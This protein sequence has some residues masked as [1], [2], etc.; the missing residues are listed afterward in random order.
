MKR[1]THPVV[2]QYRRPESL[3]DGSIHYGG[4]IVPAQRLMASV[5]AR[6][7]RGRA[8][9]INTILEVMLP[10][11]YASYT[12]LQQHLLLSE[13]LESR[14]LRCKADI[15]T[16]ITEETLTAFRRNRGEI[17]QS[18]RT[19]VEIGI[20]PDI[21]PTDT[22]EKALF[23]ALYSDFLHDTRSSVPHLQAALDEWEDPELF[24]AR[25]ATVTPYARRGGVAERDSNRICDRPVPTPLGRPAAFYFQGFVYVRPMQS[26][27]MEAAE[28]TN[29][30]VYHLR[31]FDERAPE[32][33]DVW[34]LNPHFANLNEVRLVDDPTGAEDDIEPS[35][36]ASANSKKTRA[37][38]K[39]LSVVRFDDAF[40][41]ARHVQDTPDTALVAPMC[42]DVRELLETFVESEPEKTR[43]LAYPV[44]R[45]L[46]SL[47]GMWNE[48]ANTL[49][50]TP[51]T[52]RVCLAT[53][54]ADEVGTKLGATL[55]V[56]DRVAP[57]FQD[58]RRLSDWCGR[59][60]RLTEFSTFFDATFAPNQT[61][62]T[63]DEAR[64]RHLAASPLAS[65]AV[66]QT[67]SE[68]IT[69]L[70]KAIKR[71]VNDASL[72][73]GEEKPGEKARKADGSL[74]LR[75]HFARLKRLLS[76]RA[77][78]RASTSQ[79]RRI[80]G[81][82]LERLGSSPVSITHCPPNHLADAMGFFLGGRCEPNAEEEDRKGLHRVMSLA[83]AEGAVL[84][85]RE[86]PIMLCCA[87]ATS[88]PSGA[89]RPSWP[90]TTDL[91]HDLS[92]PE[93]RGA[94]LGRLADQLHYLENT[95]LAD[96][97]FFHLLRGHPEITLSW[98][99]ARGEKMLQPSIYLQ[100]AGDMTNAVTVSRFLMDK[101]TEAEGKG[102]GTS[103]GSLEVPPALKTMST[104]AQ[105]RFPDGSRPI[106]MK[107]AVAACPCSP[108]RLWY[109]FVLSGRPL[110]EN[111]FQLNFLITATIAVIATTNRC[112]IEE[113][114]SFFF[115]LYP[116]I[117]EVCRAESE[118][119]AR[120]FANALRKN[121]TDWS[122]SDYGARVLRLCLH[123]LPTSHAQKVLTSVKTGTP[124][125]PKAL[126]T[127]C[128]HNSYCRFSRE[129]QE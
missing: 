15:S 79:E 52:V 120:I 108:L 93:L 73:F 4:L 32:A 81:S 74:N 18:V 6:S 8:C 123:H 59:A 38:S 10:H 42:T 7:G 97:Y 119:I 104:A 98:V 60:Q 30:P 78:L 91:L 44:G 36:V 99:V 115:S 28:R 35:V 68:E 46:M 110:Y 128:P 41:L 122:A 84:R 75:V 3:T 25:L 27:F 49:D 43:L 96:R 124:L 64:W 50:V 62:T 89:L 47:Y 12:L 101:D 116:A 19:L 23:R 105:K 121:G 114:A 72:L 87:D 103:S 113:S 126:C 106:E 5:Y 76:E 24:M 1:L 55:G 85:W 102:V 83:D 29:V 33:Y 54:W 34:R 86:N 17:V 66:F 109:G 125:N 88:L 21:L 13:L 100:E 95:T 65:F 80:A 127:F 39:K 94:T 77:S 58:C 129:K 112:S 11:W 118:K 56:F 26:R 61:M 69:L 82:L 9:D 63:T 107:G 20:D 14:T 67:S 51:E 16:P 40:S 111:D 48:K 92:R 71:M 57:Y 117:P 37:S 2:L 70:T 53:G 22:A 90:L 31:A 45:Y